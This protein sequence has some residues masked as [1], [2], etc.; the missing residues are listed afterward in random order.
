MAR[1]AECTLLANG[2]S[3][4]LYITDVAEAANAWRVT[5]SHLETLDPTNQRSLITQSAYNPCPVYNCFLR[6]LVV[7]AVPPAGTAVGSNVQ[8]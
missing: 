5:N 2:A 7:N 3:D 8:E 1:L 6:G 4:A